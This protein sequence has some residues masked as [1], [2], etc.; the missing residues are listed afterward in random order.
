M[1]FPK[2]HR[3]FSVRSLTLLLKLVT[4]DFENDCNTAA[5]TCRL[6]FCSVYFQTI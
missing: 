4:A 2:I 5:T 1:A 6:N 3:H